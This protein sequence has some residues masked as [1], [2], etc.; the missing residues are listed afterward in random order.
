MS[1]VHD[2]NQT[3]GDEGDT[4]RF[5]RLHGQQK[6]IMAAPNGNGNGDGMRAMNIIQLLLLA[7]LVG[8]GTWAVTSIQSQGKSIT[9]MQYQL[10]DATKGRWGLVHQ[11]DY[12]AQLGTLNA[13][14][15]TPDVRR[16]S[17]ENEP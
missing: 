10:R 16:I 11:L 7:V 17:K 13:T 15:R 4:T 8:I 6:P 9:D 1:K 12:N 2:I 3:G 5:L 14:L